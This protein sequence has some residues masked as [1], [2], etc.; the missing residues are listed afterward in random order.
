MVQWCSDERYV[1]D[2]LR[3]RYSGPV[4]EL[5]E[6]VDK[7]RVQYPDRFVP[8]IAPTFGGWNARL[9]ALAQDPGPKTVP[10]NGGSGMLC[11]EN[12]DPTATRHKSFLAEYG[13]DVCDVVAWN[14]CPW[15]AEDSKGSRSK[16]E[17][18][19]S[20]RALSRFLTMLPNLKVVM[21]HGKVAREAWERLEQ[22]T[23]LATEHGPS[24]LPGRVHTQ[25]I[26]P[27]KSWHLSAKVVDPRT[28]T[29]AEIERFNREIHESFADAAKYLRD[30]PEVFWDPE[31]PWNFDTSLVGYDDPP[32]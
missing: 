4:G 2:L 23:P 10:S 9:L 13:I 16:D 32:F 1:K 11:V 5:N 20:T 24:V 30:S 25:R 27:I 7:L 17:E 3:R 19:A 21:L 8:Y 12:D 14:S 6:F 28:K 31:D 22:Y 29:A 15:T 18:L 26:Y